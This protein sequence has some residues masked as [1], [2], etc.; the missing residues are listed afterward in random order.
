M[1]FESCVYSFVPSKEINVQE[2]LIA[3]RGE[4]AVRIVR[5]CRDMG[6]E[7]VAVYVPQDRESLH[8]RLADEAMALASPLRYGDPDEILAIA[9]QTGA[10]AIHPGYGF[11][12]EE[13]DFVERCVREGVAFIGPPAPVIQTLKDKMEALDTVKRAGYCVPLYAELS[14]RDEPAQTPA[15]GSRTWATRWWSSRRAAAAAAGPAS[16]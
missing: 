1:C 9:R 4:I 13:P 5:T 12:A 3:N 6:I 7:T 16:S 10:D 2:V 15:G 14:D 8:V 11:L